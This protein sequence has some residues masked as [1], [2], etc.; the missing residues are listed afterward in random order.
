MI[1]LSNI[2]TRYIVIIISFFTVTFYALAI[3]NDI[4]KVALISTNANLKK[5]DPNDILAM[6]Q[7][8]KDVHE[9]FALKNMRYWAA[10]GTLLGAVRHKGIIPWD[11]D[12]DIFIF[13]EDEKLLLSLMPIFKQLGYALIKKRD[14]VYILYPNERASY[15]NC[16][17]DIIL[18]YQDNDKIFYSCKILQKTYR[19]ENLPLYF[20]KKELYP[21]QESVFSTFKIT[22]P[23]DPHPYLYYAY[24]SDYMTHAVSNKIRVALSEYD[25]IP[26]PLIKSLIDKV[27][28]LLG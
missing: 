15:R 22:I 13:Q 17:L 19:R 6:Y 7:M 24:G 9:V 16:H 28:N 27:I 21:F 23:V 25:K 14:Y 18:A 2:V 20:T 12:L 11:N 26:A 3:D 4:S 8:M 10:G 1:F 5:A